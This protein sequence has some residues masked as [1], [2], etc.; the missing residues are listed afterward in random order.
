MDIIETAVLGG[1]F[2]PV[3]NG[4]LAIAKDLLDRELAQEVMFVP[5]ARP[6]HKSGKK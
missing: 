3:H 6:P 2:D 1:T 4:H 5:S